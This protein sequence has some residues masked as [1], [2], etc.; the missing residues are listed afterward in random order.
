MLARVSHVL[1]ALITL[2]AC[3]SEDSDPGGYG[4]NGGTA[5]VGSGGTAGVGPGGSGP[6]GSGPGGSGPGGSGPGGS[7]GGGAVGGTGAGS[8]GAS[9]GGTGGVGGTGATAGT[10]GG[11]GGTEVTGCGSTKLLS[12]PATNQ[13]GPWPVGQITTELG[14]LKNVVVLYPAKPGSQAGKEPYRFDVRSVLPPAERAKVPESDTKYVSVDSYENLPIDDAH[15]P[16]PAV[17]LVHGTASFSVASAGTMAHWASRG[18]IAMAG[19]HPLLNFTDQLTTCPLIPNVS[20]TIG[21]EVDSEI[22]ALKTPSGALAPLAGKIDM[23]RIGLAGHS[24]G[25]YNVAGFSDKPGVQVVIALSGTLAVKASSSL[26][27]SLFVG[28][29]ADTVLPYNAGGPGIGLIYFPGNGSQRQAYDAT[30]GLKRIVG[31]TGGGHLAPTE[32][33]QTN[34]A[35]QN[36]IQVAQARGVACLGLIPALFDCGTINWAKGVEIVND[37]TAGVLEETLH[38]QDRAAQISAIKSRHPE[39]GEFLEAR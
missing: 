22:A 8:G 28:G 25:A 20:T 27:S 13:R 31:I 6:G 34:A 32:L 21:A 39:A 12:N 10:G 7:G 30:T 2:A 23:T 18:F 19:N 16:Y 11:G 14:T 38:C 3:R 1:V 33:C 37:I 5:G 9:G 15:G 4:A 24:A 17:I 36:A 26:K 29:I 35:G